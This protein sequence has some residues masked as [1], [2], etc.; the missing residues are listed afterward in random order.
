MISLILL[1]KY[2]NI[3][4]DLSHIK[5]G[6]GGGVYTINVL[7]VCLAVPYLLLLLS[8]LFCEHESQVVLSVLQSF[9]CRDTTLLLCAGLIKL[10]IISLLFIFRYFL[11]DW[12]GWIAAYLTLTVVKKKKKKTDGKIK[13][14]CLNHK[15]VILVVVVLKNVASGVVSRYLR[16]EM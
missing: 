13:Y 16:H 4:T 5:R 3:S 6:V 8:Q 2:M 10:S 9:I 15:T 1:L 11:T 12:T 14:L 7:L